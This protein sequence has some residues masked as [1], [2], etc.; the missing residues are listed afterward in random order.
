M[1][2]AGRIADLKQE[3][4]GEWLAIRVTRRE[5]WTPV[6][7][8]LLFHAKDREE[9]FRALRTIKLEHIY[10]TH[11]GPFIKEGYAIAFSSL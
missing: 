3:Y 4:Q 7:G 1:K 11:A 10:I 8:Q 9:L 5:D 6:E 2:T